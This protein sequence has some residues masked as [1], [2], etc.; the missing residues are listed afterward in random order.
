MKDLTEKQAAVARER[1]EKPCFKCGEIKPL[2][3]FHRQASMLDGR[4]N[5]C[6]I[7][8]RIDIGNSRNERLEHYKRVA[9]EIKSRPIAAK[10]RRD[11]QNNTIE[12][13]AAHQRALAKQRI[14]APYKDMARQAV[15][16]ALRTGRIVRQPCRDCGS[17]KAEAH[18]SDYSKPLDVIWLCNKHH[19]DEHER[20]KK[21]EN[22]T[23]RADRAARPSD[24]YTGA[25]SA[26]E[27]SVT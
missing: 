17:I 20:I 12:G 9:K 8:A 7:C 6:K 22:D 1:P 5:K 11:Y 21:Q 18:H 24:G 15:S 23:N 13:K 19:H 25:T 26:A 4:L 16:Y 2:E 3:D 14:L 10:A 27:N